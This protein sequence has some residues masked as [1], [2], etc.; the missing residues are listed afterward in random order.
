MRTLACFLLPLALAAQVAPPSIHDLIT[1][2]EQSR[3]RRTVERLASFGTRHSL[4]ETVSETRG[5]GAA[6]RWLAE[7][8]EALTRLPNSR[9]VAFEDRF[10][11][12]PGP[13][14][15]R[16]VEMVNVGVMLPGMDQSRTGEALVVVAHYD[17]RAT[18]VMDAN[19]DA[20]GAVDDASGVA[21]AFEMA[22]VMAGEQPAINIYFVAVAGEEQ[23]QVGSAH[24]V[25]RLKAEGV[26]VVGALSLDTV[27]NVVGSNGVKDN[28]TVRFFSEGVSPLETE[29][30]RRVREQLGGENDGASRELARYLKRFGQKYVDNFECLVMLRKDRVGRTGD[31]FAFNQEGFPAVRVTETWENF[32]RQ[33]QTPRVVGNHPF[34]DNPAYFEPGYAVKV[35][36]VLMAALRQLALAPAAP[37]NVVLGGAATADARLSWT[38][39]TDPRIRGVVVYRRRADGV[40]WE[41][42]ESF[43]R[44]E[45][46][47][48]KGSGTDNFYYAVASV[49]AE[50]NESL[51][52]AVSRIE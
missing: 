20:P 46:A 17:S 1:R 50:G 30:Q 8:A 31:H 32:D 49:D 16:P 35:T 41:N 37:E 15:P 10:T 45:S 52:T 42:T 44:V 48:L 14:L 22:Q 27:G 2:V 26:R 19:G 6:R 21:M 47:I 38:L 11:A 29:A 13:R 33:H 34:G 3:E 7:E 43:G 51:P 39:Q 24:L 40:Q 18:D 4:S 12:E 25:K 28:A 23:G 36:R 9:L 5:I